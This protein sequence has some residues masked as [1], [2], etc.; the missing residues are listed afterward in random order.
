MDPIMLSRRLM[1]PIMLSRRLCVPHHGGGVPIPMPPVLFSTGGV[2]IIQGSMCP[3]RSAARPDMS[4]SAGRRMLPY[5]S[6][7]EKISPFKLRTAP[8][9]AR[10]LMHGCGR[11]ITHK[12]DAFAPCQAVDCAPTRTYLADY[13]AD[14][15]AFLQRKGLPWQKS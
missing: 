3:L 13:L 15:L 9:S 8:R 5:I 1:D 10:F 12:K 4:Y 2:D 11:N 14:Y 6:T 7:T